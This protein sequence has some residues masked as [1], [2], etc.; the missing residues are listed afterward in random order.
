MGNGFCFFSSYT[1]SFCA[2][3]H[4][5]CF[6]C[7]INLSISF[8]LSLSCTP[9]SHFSQREGS[10]E[11]PINTNQQELPPEEGLSALVLTM[12]F[13]HSSPLSNV[14]NWI[15]SFEFHRLPEV[16]CLWSGFRFQDI[17][18]RFFFLATWGNK[19]KNFLGGWGAVLIWHIRR[20]DNSVIGDYEEKEQA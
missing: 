7:L 11:S 1:F 5:V 17:R 20:K 19:A 18:D 16:M 3:S 12:L 10:S 14:V 15:E 8:C 13:S 4:F 6:C 9:S 2:L